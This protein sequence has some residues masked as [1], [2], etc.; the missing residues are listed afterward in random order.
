MDTV[1]RNSSQLEIGNILI[2]LSKLCTLY[3]DTCLF[4][5]VKSSLCNF[6]IILII[7]VISIIS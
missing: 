3:I 1:A 7:S 6:F 2:F 4:C 5:L